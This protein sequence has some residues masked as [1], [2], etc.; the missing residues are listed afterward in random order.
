M[1]TQVATARRTHFAT[2]DKILKSKQFRNY[3]KEGENEDEFAWLRFFSKPTHKAYWGRGKESVTL[4]KILMCWCA[5]AAL[6]IPSRTRTFYK[7]LPSVTS[8]SHQ[9]AVTEQGLAV[10]QSAN[11]LKQFRFSANF[12]F[13]SHFQNLHRVIIPQN[14]ALKL[15]GNRGFEKEVGKMTK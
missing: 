5:F 15:T 3:V 2:A 8:G 13:G 12:K 6:G 10:R 9:S 1:L 11:H 7:P 14:Y 4:S